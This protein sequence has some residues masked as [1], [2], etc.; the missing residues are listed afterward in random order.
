MRPLVLWLGLG[1]LSVVA[2]ADFT[3]I[4]NP[5]DPTFNQSLG[6]NNAGTIAG[7]FGSG[8]AGHPN[9]GYTV[10]PPYGAPD[11]TNENFPGSAQTQVV[12][13]NNVGITVGFWIDGSN[14]NF[15]FVDKGGTFTSV[16]DP[17]TPTTG[18]TTNQLLGVNDN[19]VAAGFYN[20]SG[21][22]SHAYT[23][24]IGA[25]TFAPI[26]PTG[27]TSAFASDIN[28]AGLISGVAVVGGVTEGFLDSSG[29]FTFFEVPGATSTQFL[30]INNNGQAV[31]FYVDAVGNTHGLIY[32]IGTSSYQSVDDPSAAGTTAFNGV[33]DEGQIVGFYVDANG[34]TIGLLTSA[35]P[36]P[37]WPMIA[38]VALLGIVVGRRNG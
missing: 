6:I 13:I 18:T 27:A 31:G 8:A 24:N 11:F 5:S 4:I 17:S 7:Y 35:V 36:E 3:N 25:T 28:N 20:D 12:G 26:N 1:L 16:N 19:G 9:Q 33:N 37:R 14:N 21:G 34:N 32:N 15:G 2:R 22:N 38:V 30:G 10:V 29:T 23:Y